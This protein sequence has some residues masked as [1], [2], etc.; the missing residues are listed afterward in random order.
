MG[1]RYKYEIVLEM[2]TPHGGG[3]AQYPLPTMTCNFLAKIVLFPYQEKF[4]KKP[5]AEYRAW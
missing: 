5:C 1:V 4:L 3:G 2:D